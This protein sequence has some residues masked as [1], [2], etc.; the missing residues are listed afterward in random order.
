MAD[1]D[2]PV[3]VAFST[4]RVVAE[5]D[6]WVV[7]G[8]PL[9]GG[10]SVS[11]AS[12]WTRSGA[13]AALDRLVAAVTPAPP[14]TD[15]P[16]GFAKGTTGGAGYEDRVVSTLADAGPGSLRGAAQTGRAR[17]MFEPGLKGTLDLTRPVLV[18][19][20]CT[21]SGRGADVTITRSGL[22]V[23]EAANVI[24]EDLA[25]DRYTGDAIQITSSSRVWVPHCRFGRGVD[26]AIDATQGSTDVEVAWCHFWRCAKTMLLGAGKQEGTPE[27]VR[28]SVHHNR[29]ERCGERCPQARHGWYHV[30]NNL[31][32]RW[33][34][35]ADSGYAVRAGAGAL[36]LLESNVFV[37]A[38]PPN[39]RAVLITDT[40]ADPTRPPAI[41]SRG[42][43]PG[44]SATVGT[45]PRLVPWPELVQIPQADPA[46]ADLANRVRAGVGPRR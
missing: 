26:G 23:H 42:N 3:L 13:V 28:M 19:S 20:D 9:A 36:M 15:D 16:I 24:I 29:F 11:L 34:Y 18:R 45:E 5:G 6:R 44:P 37:P 1:A 2:R 31:Y 10:A 35:S 12:A 17:I 38:T 27:L 41:V 22:V 39:V 43:W 46:G 40:D 33:G 32:D 4:V 7:R 21:I 14:S 8:V 25:F 30:F